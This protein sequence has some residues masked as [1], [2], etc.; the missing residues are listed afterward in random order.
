MGV[1]GVSAIAYL[2][3]N[4]QSASSLGFSQRLQGHYHSL[5]PAVK[6]T[7]DTLRAVGRS[8]V[9]SFTITLC[10]F[11]CE[12]ERKRGVCFSTLDSDQSS[13]TR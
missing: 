11:V 8:S 7:Q 1:G 13:L 9:D 10:F 6:R 12:T 4:C 5:C 3:V 2:R